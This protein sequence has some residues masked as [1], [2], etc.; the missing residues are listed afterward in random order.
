MRHIVY[1]FGMVAMLCLFS[2][3]AWAQENPGGG[4]G[5]QFDPEAFRKQMLDRL[6]E[7]LGVTED[8]W[9]AL[10]PKVEAVQKLVM[11][12]RMRGGNMFGRRRGGEDPNQP[13]P[14]PRNELEKKTRELQALADNKDADPKAVKD[15]MKEIRDLREKAKGD[16]KKAQDELRELLTPRQ[17]AQLLLMGYL[18]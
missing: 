1:V 9:K 18:E 16:L 5:R 4:G 7:R 11:E 17:E 12:S 13:Q 8:E 14:E 10:Q 2:G 3:G 15:K 6:K